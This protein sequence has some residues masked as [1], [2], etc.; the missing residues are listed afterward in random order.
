MALVITLF[1]VALVTVL[2]LEYY[3]DASVELDMA[4][5]YASDAQAYSLALSGVN[6]AQALLLRDDREV[7]G[8]EDLCRPVC[9]RNNCCHCW[10]KHPQGGR[11]YLR[12]PWAL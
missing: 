7:D 3:F 6:M 1:V 2:V 4:A 9:R 11:S 10:V 12:N 8:P 5:N